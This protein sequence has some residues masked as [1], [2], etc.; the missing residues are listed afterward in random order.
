MAVYTTLDFT[1]IYNTKQQLIKENTTI[2]NEILCEA[3]KHIADG[4]LP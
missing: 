3:S 2:Q 1:I 4:A